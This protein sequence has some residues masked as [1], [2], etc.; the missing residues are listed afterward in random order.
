MNTKKHSKDSWLYIEPY[1][2]T[3]I[4]KDSL[5]MYNT[6]DG[7]SIYCKDKI[8]IEIIRKL[9][10]KEF[11]GVISI[12]FDQ[13]CEENINHFII[14]LRDKYMGDVV[15]KDYSS[16][17]QIQIM[18]YYNYP[19][20]T[21]IS[22]RN[23]FNIKSNIL[24]NIHEI[25]IELNN[26]TN[27]PSL[28][29]FL[30]FVPK[31]VMINITLN[32]KI[33]NRLISFINLL[34]F[35][36][37]YKSVYYIID[38]TFDFLNKSDLL[39]IYV[40]L[41]IDHNIF[42][43]KIDMLTNNKFNYDI[44]FQVSS[45]NNISELDFI[46]NKYNIL[47][48][49]IE[50]YYDNNIDFFKKYVFLTEDDILSSPIKL[51]DIFLNK[52]VNIFDY[53]IIRIKDNGDIYANEHFPKLGNISE[54]SIYDVVKKELETGKSWLRIRDYRPCNQCIYQWL[55]SSPSDFEL[56]LGI[57]NLCHINL[58]IK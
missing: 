51:K 34:D 30:S 26:N 38:K 17:K 9:K 18:P 19:K 29:N 48:Y 7:N 49:K 56:E 15:A 31:N 4:V 16:K 8:V 50:P 45:N 33:N 12:D 22:H 58:E 28:S 23:N 6:L 36:K 1:V 47:N 24:E 39:H 42:K 27:I 52:S 53:G 10:K 25:N 46:I 2:Y 5:F 37:T 41:P 21:Q 20:Y 32:T 11:C 54:N 40:K 13:L 43:Q 3:H 44:I 35:P 57:P 55:C 14:E